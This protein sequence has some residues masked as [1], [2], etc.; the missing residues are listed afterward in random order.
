MN[1][2]GVQKESLKLLLVNTARTAFR[3]SFID[4]KSQV[5]SP[6]LDADSCIE[7]ARG[8]RARLRKMHKNNRRYKRNPA[9]VRGSGRLNCKQNE[10]TKGALE[11]TRN[12]ATRSMASAML[13]AGT[14]VNKWHSA[15]AVE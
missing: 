5:Y 10:I 12:E 6:N 3:L 7:T 9:F 15:R 8:R 14:P 11:R 1:L 4:C 2:T 13:A